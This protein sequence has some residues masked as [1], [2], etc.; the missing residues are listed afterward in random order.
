ML[1]TKTD[2]Q[3]AVTRAIATVMSETGGDQGRVLDE[4]FQLFENYS[5]DE[6]IYRPD[7]RLLERINDYEDL[8]AG[9][10]VEDPGKLMEEITFLA[11]RCISGIEVFKS[12]Q[13][14][15]PQHDLVV[16]G[17]TPHW[18]FFIKYLQLDMENRTIVIEAKNEA[19]PVSDSQFSRLCSIIQN[20]FPNCRLGVFVARKGASGFPL[21]GRGNQIRQ[22]TLTNARATQLLFRAMTNK[23]VVILDHNDILLLREQGSLPRLLEAK[24][25]DIDEASGIPLTF[26]EDWK[27]IDLPSHLAKYNSDE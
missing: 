25:R 9:R 27:E 6:N 24:I 11:F 3:E 18:I 14:Y 17:S 8:C 5:L 2:L 15:A 22:R 19:T 10:H 13:S 7:N 16:S 21:R 12:F 1:Q 26:D 23:Y 20:K 4:F